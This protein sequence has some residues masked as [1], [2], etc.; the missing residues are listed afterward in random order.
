MVKRETYILVDLTAYR[1]THDCKYKQFIHKEF[2]LLVKLLSF[3]TLSQPTPYRA[4]KGAA[5]LRSNTLDALGGKDFLP[6]L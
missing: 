5:T 6:D 2:C 3:F 4:S 1:N